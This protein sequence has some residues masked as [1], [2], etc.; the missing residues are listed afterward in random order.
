MVEDVPMWKKTLDA[1][2]QSEGL[3]DTERALLLMDMLSEPGKYQ[4]AV[5]EMDAFRD[6]CDQ[7]L[8]D[9]TGV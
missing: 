7:L 5:E 4:I 2:W 3:S 8:T 1:Y 6:Y 9:I